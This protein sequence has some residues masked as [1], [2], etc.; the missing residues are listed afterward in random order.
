[1]C[2]VTKSQAIDKVQ[3]KNAIQHG[4]AILKS[5]LTL[6]SNETQ[7]LLQ[8]VLLVPTL[9]YMIVTN[10]DV[11]DGLINGAS[12]VLEKID[13]FKTVGPDEVVSM[14]WMSF[15]NPKVGIEARKKH[16]H[17]IQG[18]NL[19]KNWVPIFHDSKV[20]KTWPGRDVQ[21]NKC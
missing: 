21:V 19:P 17:I 16:K 15:E 6:D 1:M 12:G 9:K 20:I 3:G 2:A 4:D 13:V 7:G 8:E 5:V 10:V 11:R 14:V 18:K